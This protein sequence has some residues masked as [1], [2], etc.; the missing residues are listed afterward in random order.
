MD[1][2]KYFVS[3]ICESMAIKYQLITTNFP[4]INL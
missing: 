3:L 2:S 4:V 1:N